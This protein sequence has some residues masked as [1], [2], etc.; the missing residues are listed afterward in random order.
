MSPSY[1]DFKIRKQCAVVF[2]FNQLTGL[3][4]PIIGRCWTRNYQ[5]THLI[6]TQ[7]NLS[8]NSFL[9]NLVTKKPKRNHCHTR[10]HA[11]GKCR[12]ITFGASSKNQ[13]NKHEFKKKKTEYNRIRVTRFQQPGT[14]FLNRLISQVTIYAHR[15][16]TLKQWTWK[17]TSI[18]LLLQSIKL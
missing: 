16:N 5:L 11:W 15:I 18:G 12:P 9:I 7:L 2:K 17:V 13:F 4:T 14:R 8:I 3:W 6:A 1:S 10:P